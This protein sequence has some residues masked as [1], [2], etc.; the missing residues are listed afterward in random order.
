MR[1]K[2]DLF[3]SNSVESGCPRLKQELL[4]AETIL[5]YRGTLAEAYMIVNWKTKVLKFFISVRVL[6]GNSGE[7]RKGTPVTITVEESE[8]KGLK[9]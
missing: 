5:D 1:R 7:Q 6:A 8:D 4:M 2:F 9:T 3:H